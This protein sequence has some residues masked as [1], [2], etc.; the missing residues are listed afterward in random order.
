MLN[1]EGCPAGTANARPVRDTHLSLVRPNVA[2]R[3]S[4]MNFLKFYFFNRRRYSEK[5][6]RAKK[7]IFDKIYP[8]AGI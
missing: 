8:S 4:P 7:I 3:H 1:S 2:Q 5:L 6:F